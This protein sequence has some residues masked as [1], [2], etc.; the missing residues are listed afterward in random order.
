MIEKVSDILNA[1]IKIEKEKLASFD[2]PHM[3]T[4]GSA[5]EEITKQGIDQDYIIPKHLGLKVISGFI[6]CGETLLPQQI[7]AMLVQGEGKKYGLTD[8]FIYPIEQVLCVFEVKKTLTKADLSDAFDHLRSIRKEFSNHFENKLINDQYDPDIFKAQKHFSELTGKTSPETYLD[9]HYLSKADGILF[10]SLVQESLAPI[11][12]IHG[13]GGYK[14]ESGLRNSFLDCIEEKGEI[15]K[16]G[17]GVP[18]IPNLIVSNEFSLI[19]ANGMPFLGMTD[20]REWAVLMSTRYNPARII[21]EIIWSKISVYF[22]LK[23]PWGED[24]LKESVEPLL[25]AIPRENETQAGWEYAPIRYKESF[26]ANRK[27]M[28]DWKPVE[29]G[30]EL[31][32]A[33]NFISIYGGALEEGTLD[34]IS[35]EHAIE[36]SELKSRLLDTMLF[37]YDEFNNIFRP[38]NDKTFLHTNDDES[39][40]L[41]SDD[42]RLI[43]WCNK[44]DIKPFLMSLILT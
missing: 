43:N 12:I 44:N 40:Y 25:L 36:V 29:V 24:L 13:Y 26:L 1:F 17:L 41:S 19:K 20:K 16:I 3:P 23:M 42:N 35:K 27:E 2:M 6:C 34:Y 37:M 5:Y 31:V 4:L 28:K 7:D 8:N 15:N 38:I 9:L 14:T 33:F 30:P 39:G 18:S 21:L 11:S 22:N 10:Y 32:S